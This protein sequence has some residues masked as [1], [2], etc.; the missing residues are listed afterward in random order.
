MREGS[1]PR[2]RLLKSP[3][4]AATI[5]TGFQPSQRGGWQVSATGHWSLPLAITTPE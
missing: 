2:R 4:T 3:F 5:Q 1:G